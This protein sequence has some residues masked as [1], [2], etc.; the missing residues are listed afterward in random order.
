MIAIIVSGVTCVIFVGTF[1][2]AFLKSKGVYDEYLE[3]VDKKE[4]GFKDFFLS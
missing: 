1:L 3:A 4:Y 2:L